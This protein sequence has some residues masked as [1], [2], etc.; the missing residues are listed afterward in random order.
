MAL[1]VD[2][3]GNTCSWLSGSGGCPVGS[4]AMKPGSLESIIDHVSTGIQQRENTDVTML[5]F[6]RLQFS[7]GGE[8]GV[9]LTP[10]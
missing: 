4:S 6:V 10:D 8:T 3:G 5:S 1:R 9:H 7:S 2:G